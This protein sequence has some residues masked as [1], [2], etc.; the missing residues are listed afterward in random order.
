[1]AAAGKQ[2]EFDVLTFFIYVMIFLTVCVGGFALYFHTQVS[3]AGRKIKGEVNQLKQMEK[4]ALDSD[5]RN[6][7]S[8]DRD[9][10]VKTDWKA[11]DFQTIYV[12]ASRLNQIDL[13]VHSQESARQ[14]AN[15]TELVFA[16]TFKNCRVENLIKFLLKVQK[17]WPGARVKE[18]PNL[19]YIERKGVK[20]WDA[21]VKLSIF[22]SAAS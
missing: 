4:L 3:K 6:W 1:M 11:S 5:F 7:V 12:N 15:G 19:K 20:G 16:L 13:K 22:R 9:G 2:D 21:S 10:K 18:I 17:D 8:R 14:V